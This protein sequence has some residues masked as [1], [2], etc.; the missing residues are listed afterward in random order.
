M[1]EKIALFWGDDWEGLYING[2][3]IYENH[4]IR[5]HEIITILEKHGM[6]A[7]CVEV[8]DYWLMENGRLPED[9][10]DVLVADQ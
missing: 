6:D 5:A 1:I 3:L 8:N 2:K 9:A 7:T 10:T 4:S